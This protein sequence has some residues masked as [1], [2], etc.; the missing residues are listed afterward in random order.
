MWAR[1][2]VTEVVLIDD[3]STDET[4]LATARVK[5]R[6]GARLATERFEVNR[7]KGTAIRQAAEP[8]T[9]ELCLIQD[10]DLEYG[11]DDCPALLEPL[12][13]GVADVTFGARGFTGHSAFSF[14]FVVGNRLIDLAVNVLCNAD[15]TDIS[16][17]YKAMPTA[18]LRA[19][20]LTSRRFAFDPE[21]VAKTGG[22]E[23]DPAPGR[24]AAP[25]R[26]PALPLRADPA[27]ASAGPAGFA[28]SR[29]A[30]GQGRRTDLTSGA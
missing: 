5:E 24:P 16:C 2:E 29:A 23:E 3:G 28:L 26:S 13:T 19:A 11:P 1:P 6:F 15:M 18:V 7:G 25:G 20:E 21:I 8:A 14:W 10:A 12:R 9:G 30:L 22:G 4:P 27:A 17:C